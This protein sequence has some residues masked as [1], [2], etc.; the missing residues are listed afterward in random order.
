MLGDFPDPLASMCRR[1]GRQGLAG[2]LLVETRAGG[3]QPGDVEY[4]LVVGHGVVFWFEQLR[5]HPPLS[6]NT[7]G[8]RDAAAYDGEELARS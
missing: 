1:R 5:V 4:V 7:Y 8:E 6:G 2:A 3:D